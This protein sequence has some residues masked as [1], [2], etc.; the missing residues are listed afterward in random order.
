M[1]GIELQ[2]R[3]FFAAIR[4][5][6]EPNASVAQ[7]LP[8]YRTLDRIE[9]SFRRSSAGII[10][11]GWRSPVTWRR[12]RIDAAPAA[13]PSSCNAAANPGCPARCARVFM[14]GMVTT[15]GERDS[16]HAMATCAAV[17]PCVREAISADGTRPGARCWPRPAC[18][19]RGWLR[20]CIALRQVRR[21]RGSCPPESHAPAGCRK[22][23]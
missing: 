11:G 12:E 22:R 5:G 19:K 18:W 7:V 9:K 15:R 23:R 10:A 14:P 6:R 1:N 20:R 2:D 13:R 4:E 8:A 17:A 3:E 16:T 21:R